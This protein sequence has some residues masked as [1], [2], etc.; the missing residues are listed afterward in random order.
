[1]EKNKE[2][3]ECLGCSKLTYN[4]KY[5]SISCFNKNRDYNFMKGDNNPA[6]MK[7]VRKKISDGIFDAYS[8][9]IVMGFQKGHKINN[10]RVSPK[11]GLNFEKYYGRKKANDIIN[12][13]VETKKKLFNSGEIKIWSDGLSCEEFLSHFKDNKMWNAGLPSSEQP[14]YGFKHSKKAKKQISVSNKK[15]KIAYFSD[16]NKS[17]VTREKIKKARLNQ[18]FPLKDTIPEVLLQ[19]G[20]NRRNIN[21]IT[22]KLIF[23]IEHKYQCDIFIEPNIIIEADGNYWHNYPIG[24]EIDHIRIKELQKAGY[25]VLRFWE[26][27]IKP[28]PEWCVDFIQNFINRGE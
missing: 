21:F 17:K 18:V 13:M 27:E 2:K 14:H 20:L 15:T 23:G 7:Y 1:M 19:E 10:G 25:K 26:S 22:H 3:K 12:K 5:C 16:L 24:R 6:K 9:D 28:H 8:K 11:K 4:Q